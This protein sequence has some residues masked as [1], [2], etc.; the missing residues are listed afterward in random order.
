M[1][2]SLSP[3]LAAPPR[4]C[5]AE[6]APGLP[7]NYPGSGAPHPN[8]TYCGLGWDRGVFWFGTFNIRV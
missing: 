6:Q 2:G 1:G 3:G 5:D 8:S 4:P 7:Q